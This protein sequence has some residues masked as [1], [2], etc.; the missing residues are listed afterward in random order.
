MPITPYIMAADMVSRADAGFENL[1]GL[2]DCAE[3]LYEFGSEDQRE[4]F[5]PRV[6]AGETMSMDLT[7]PD[8]GSDLQAVMLKATYN[9]ADQPVSYTHLDVYKRQGQTC[10]L[11]YCKEA[12]NRSMLYGGVS[13]DSES[14]CD[15]DTIVGTESRTLSVNPSV[16]NMRLDRILVEV[17]LYVT[18]LLADHIHVTLEDDG[19]TVLHAWCSTLADDYIARLVLCIV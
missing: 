15:S 6:C 10:L 12:L 7:E 17:M 3:T 2:Q 8:A 1:W 4:R 19:L 13:Q 14:C 5:L 11:I 9:E 16:G 18:I